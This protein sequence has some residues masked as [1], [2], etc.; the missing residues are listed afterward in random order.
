MSLGEKDPESGRGSRGARLRWLI[1]AALTAAVLLG[2]A[3][4]VD[5]AE[6][7][8]RLAEAEPV[9]LAV[10]LGLMFASRFVVDAVRWRLALA[11]LGCR[12][13]FA[14]AL[15]LQASSIPLRLVTPA[16]SG[17]LVSAFYLQRRHELPVARALSSVLLEKCHNLVAY[18]GL[19][20]L[21]PLAGAVSGDWALTVPTGWLVAGSAALIAGASLGWALRERV[22]ARLGPRAEKLTQLV[23][24]FWEIGPA[25]QLV[26]F[27]LTALG[28]GLEFVEFHLLFQAVG[29]HLPL[30]ALTYGLAVSILISNLPLTLGGVGTREAAALV[31]F[32]PLA[33]AEGILAAMAL[34][35]AAHLLL[36]AALGALS[37]PL[38][39]S[40]LRRQPP[41]T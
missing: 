28:M 40:R 1:A 25:G 36:P 19:V 35:Y 16:K 38:F 14:E 24:A 12:L 13:G 33:D 39:F 37:L 21:L 2:L 34:L 10:A 41:R 18:V 27:A 26:L 4:F 32:A 15:L 3:A 22:L 7:T 6:V 9:T 11:G 29:V 17:V 30:T 20:A 23:S 8:A 5:L 31:L